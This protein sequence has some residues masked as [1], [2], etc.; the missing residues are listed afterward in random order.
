[1]A[2]SDGIKNNELDT[3]YSQRD[4]IILSAIRVDPPLIGFPNAYYYS[5]WKFHTEL[6]FNSLIWRVSVNGD[7]VGLGLVLCVGLDR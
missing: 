5:L 1:M 6:L 3:A 2:P 7:K 4:N